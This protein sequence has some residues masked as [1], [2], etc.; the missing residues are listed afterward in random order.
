MYSYYGYLL[1]DNPLGIVTDLFVCASIISQVSRWLGMRACK[2][3]S[4][5]RVSRFKPKLSL[6]ED[7]K[8]EPLLFS[9]L[10][11]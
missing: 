9:G 4:V 2:E 8:G 5:E 10:T 7:G 6:V 1:L 11:F 3:V